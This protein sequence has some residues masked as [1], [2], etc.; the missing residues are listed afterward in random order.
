[1]KKKLEETQVNES[2][3]A[4]VAANLLSFCFLAVAGGSIL[5]IGIAWLK[6][7]FGNIKSVKL[8]ASQ[9][10][11]FKEYCK[12]LAK[13][14]DDFKKYNEEHKEVYDHCSELNT[15]IE[16]GE[17]DWSDK[18]DLATVLTSGIGKSTMYRSI[19]NTKLDDLFKMGNSKELFHQGTRIDTARKIISKIVS[20]EDRKK[21]EELSLEMMDKIKGRWD[22][23]SKS[24]FDF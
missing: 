9:M 19:L 4:D 6:G 14:K 21:M 5:S 1:M 12:I 8:A 16:F 3:V 24:M 18:D 11:N 2:I 13:Y 20:E 10:T 15:L 7:V 17:K 22:K 23:D